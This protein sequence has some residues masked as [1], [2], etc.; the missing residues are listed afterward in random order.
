MKHKLILL[1]FFSLFIS[2]AISQNDS[3]DELKIVTDSISKLMQ[4]Y[5]YNPNEL[6]SKNYLKISKKMQKIA[7]SSKTKDEFITAFN[8]LWSDGPFSHVRIDRTERS[9][10]EIA[11][12]IDHLNMGEQAVDLTFEDKTAILRVNTMTGVDTKTKIFEAYKTISEKAPKYLIIDLR[13]NTGGTFAGV[14]LVSH[15]LERETAVG[16]FVSSKWWNNNKNEPELNDYQNLKTWEGWSI[17]TFWND[18]QEN[19]ITPVKFKPMYPSFKG[20]VYVLISNTTA[21]A[22]EFTADALANLDNV[23]LIGE[24]TAGEMLSQKMFDLPYGLQLSLPIADYYSSRMG[25]IEGIGVA[26]DIAIHNSAALDLTK[27]L[28]DGK[29][30]EEAL[31]ETKKALEEKNQEPFK[32]EKLYLFGSM[33]EWGKDWDNS[34]Q[35]EY[36][37]DGVYT[38]SINLKPG[39]YEFK[40]APMHWKFDF[41]S[42]A[43]EPSTLK[44]GEVLS[45]NTQKGSKNILLNVKKEGSFT[46]HLDV[47]DKNKPVLKVSTSK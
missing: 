33:N 13:F 6:R 12:F 30:T 23:T 22:A 19:G 32:N 35:F 9:A 5:L 36:T 18:V 16:A 3:N 46:F 47:K 37:K 10:K 38:T 40:I 42:Q 44:L 11:Y 31:L 45:L 39:Q 17:K 41:G 8:L 27:L 21:S 20:K 14:P 43:K 25:R 1:L 34:P 2:K 7:T 15:L 4:N 28:I 29:T 24:R 26:P